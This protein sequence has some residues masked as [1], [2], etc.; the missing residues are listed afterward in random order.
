MA[1]KMLEILQLILIYRKKRKFI[2]LV[3]VELEGKGELVVM[4][5][6]LD[7]QEILDWQEIVEQLEIQQQISELMC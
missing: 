1:L 2:L 3:L 4:E 6:H 7:H 5:E